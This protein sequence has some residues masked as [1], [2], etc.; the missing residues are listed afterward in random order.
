MKINMKK[1]VILF[2]VLFLSFGLGKQ[3]DA[4]KNDFWGDADKIYIKLR[5]FQFKVKNGIKIYEFKKGLDELKVLENVLLDDW[6]EKIEKDE[7]DIREKFR[8]NDKYKLSPKEKE[9]RDRWLTKAKITSIILSYNLINALSGNI[10]IMEEI[11]DMKG[12]EDDDIEEYKNA[13]AERI[14]EVDTGIRELKDRIR[15]YYKK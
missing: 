7:D 10:Q 8:K 2:V 12:R 3:C 6:E 15:K 5:D 14:N 13:I 9:T 1:I 4:Q 11:A